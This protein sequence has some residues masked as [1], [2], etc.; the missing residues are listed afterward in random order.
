MFSRRRVLTGLL[1]P[2]ILLG[3]ILSAS[4]AVAQKVKTDAIVY[5]APT[6][7]LL[8]DQSVVRSCLGDATS[9]LVRLNARATSSDGGPIVYRW[10]SPV[11]PHYGSWGG[12]DV[13]SLRP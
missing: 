9:A 10:T 1:F 3:V 12:N 4:K 7:D 8:A 5:T 6:L 13:G 2:L 11:G